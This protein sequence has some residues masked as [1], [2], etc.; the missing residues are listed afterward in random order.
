MEKFILFGQ[1]WGSTMLKFFSLLKQ[2]PLHQQLC[3]LILR[4][5]SSLRLSRSLTHA[6]VAVLFCGLIVA[7]HAQ[8]G[9]KKIDFFDAQTWS[10][11]Q[12]QLPRPAA[13]VFTTTDCTHCPAVINSIGEQLKK[14][15]KK[16]PQVPLVVVVMDGEGHVDLLDE[17]HYRL[18]TRLFVF[19]GQNAV[20]RHSVNP[21][22]RGITPYVALLPLVGDAKFVLGKPSESDLSTWLELAKKR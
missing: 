17:P 10:V 11:M 14:R 21:S 18:A 15:A 9:A 8:A 7:S 3:E 2:R 19:N 5:Q 16:E 22:W 6:G 20:L 1:P 4:L 12:Q 13:I